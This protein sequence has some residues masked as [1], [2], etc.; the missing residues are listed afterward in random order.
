MS[1]L[2]SFSLTVMS[3]T[4]VTAPSRSLPVASSTSVPTRPGIELPSAA[5]SPQRVKLKIT[6]SAVN[7][8]PLFQVTP[9]RTCSVY[10]V[11]SSFTSQLS[12]R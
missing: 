2:V 5:L 3:S 6:S 12:S 9:L 1:G 8:S 11:A 7:V 10:S 4:L